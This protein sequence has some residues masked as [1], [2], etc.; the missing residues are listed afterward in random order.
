MKKGDKK[1]LVLLALLIAVGVVMFVLPSETASTQIQEEET[2]QEEAAADD[3]LVAK[4]DQQA[5]EFTV[6]MLA[7]APLSLE[8]LRGKVVLLNFW[9]TWCPPCQK[10]LTRVQADLIDRFEGRDFV[11]LPISR[12]EERA[13]VAE[14]LTKKGYTFNVGLD[15]DES[16]Y[17]LYASNY[18]P[19][20]FLINR[21]G[22]IVETTLGYEP[23]E[24]D[25]LL[26]L[27]E[28]TLNA[29]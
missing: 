1:L 13:T 15:T 2:A 26:K 20:N 18:I 14:F 19:R 17:K 6:E 12:G 25:S 16:I 7:G 4:V 22:V 29:R 10:E 28:M 5:P 23:A 27:I 24:F 11:F 21:H 9:A 8:S 3:S